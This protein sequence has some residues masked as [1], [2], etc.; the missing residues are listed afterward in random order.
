VTIWGLVAWVL[1]ATSW[2]VNGFSS[3]SLTEW[4]IRE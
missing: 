2:K 4:S 3:E 1:I